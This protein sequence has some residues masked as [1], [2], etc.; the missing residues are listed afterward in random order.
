MNDLENLESDVIYKSLIINDIVFKNVKVFILDNKIEI[1][2]NWS[3]LTIAI[4]SK[5]DVKMIN[6]L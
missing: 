6:N 5:D 1:V 4:V 2:D 3:G